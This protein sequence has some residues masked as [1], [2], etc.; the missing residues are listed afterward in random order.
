VRH[1]FMQ[2]KNIAIDFLTSY[3]S[4]PALGHHQ[5]I[6]KKLLSSFYYA[7]HQDFHVCFLVFRFE[8]KVNHNLS[9]PGCLIHLNVTKNEYKSAMQ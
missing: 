1:L 4:T 8:K 3:I 2:I 6:F 7:V 5:G 9:T